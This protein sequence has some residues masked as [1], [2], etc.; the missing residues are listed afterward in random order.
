MI[1][2]KLSLSLWRWSNEFQ[3]TFLKKRE[4]FKIIYAFV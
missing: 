2:P 4:A 3:N 1:K